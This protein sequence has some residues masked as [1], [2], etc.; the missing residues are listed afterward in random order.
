METAM[1]LI[2]VFLLLS[3]NCVQS[4]TNPLDV[5]VL[6]LLY[7][8]LNSPSQLSGWK[9]SG[10]DPC[11]ES[12]KGISC[13]GSDVVSIELAGLGL[14]G[15]LGYLLSNLLSLKKLD[16]SNNY[17]SEN[18]P[19][20]LP[21]NI[22][23]LNLADNKFNGNLP[24]SISSLVSLVYLNVSHNLLSQSIGDLF[25]LLQNLSDLDLSFNILSGDLPISLGLLSNLSNLYL[26]NNQLAG[27]VNV[28]SNLDLINLDIANNHFTGWIPQSFHSIPNLRID[29]NSFENVPAPPPP[30]YTPPPPHLP[31]TNHHNHSEAPANPPNGADR[32]NTSTINSSSSNTR[33][34][35]AGALTGIVAGSVAFASCAVLAT[36]FFLYKSKKDNQNQNKLRHFVGSPPVG[37]HKG[38]W[39]QF[40][41][42]IS[43]HVPTEWNF[44]TKEPVSSNVQTSSAQQYLG[45][46]DHKLRSS[47]FSTQLKSPPSNKMTGDKLSGKSGSARIPRVPITA[48]YYSVASLQ[49]ATNSFSQEYLIGEGSLGRVYRAEFSNLKILAV[50]KLDSA[51]L[52]LRDEEEFLEAVSNISHLRHPNITALVGYCAEHGQHLLVYEHISNG[53]LHDRLHF[54]DDSRT[55]SWNAR[56]KVA[57]GTARALEYLHEVCSPSVLHKSL[58]SANILLDEDLNPHLSDCGLS[59]L[60]HNTERQL[61]TEMMPSFGYS[62]PE[63]V[64]SGIYT[65]KSDVYSF[66]VMMLELLTGRKPLDGSRVRSEQSL[67]RWAMPQL[68]DIDALAKMVDPSLNGIY[69]AKSLSRFADII[70]V[71]VQPEPEF[72]PPMSEVVQ[73]LVRL[74]QRT[75]LVRRSSADE[76]GFS[77]RIPEHEATPDM[78]L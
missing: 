41:D 45:I 6:V 21:P 32:Q 69:P 13:S 24:Y 66:G 76:L 46:G 50:K 3:A 19:F 12:W 17:I 77:Y 57:L 52:F 70:A 26:Q 40:S 59:A 11:E 54:T 75:S 39:N 71:C 68:H 62:A 10:G 5:E 74:M 31:H 38:E 56:V 9:S 15:T 67:V 23:Y 48:A 18:I 63:F 64:M 58:K 16:V 47:P 44:R 22:S 37:A 49:T 34:L 8:T 7:S 25:A 72:R 55:L 27:S 35:A 2:S 65:I 4:T 29:G 1:L 51:A 30:P 60:T 78:F 36:L 42:Y 28:L 33:S 73:A 20:Q 14:N 43:S 53:A 61:S